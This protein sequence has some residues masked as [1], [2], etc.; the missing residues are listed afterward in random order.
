MSDDFRSSHFPKP[1]AMPT[2]A[3][4]KDA[5]AALVTGDRVSPH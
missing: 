5:F 2:L 1:L 3:F 4:L